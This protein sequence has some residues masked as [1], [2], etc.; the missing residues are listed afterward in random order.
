[1]MR[2]VRLAESSG[3]V[4]VDAMGFTLCREE[5]HN[6]TER[7]PDRSGCS[8]VGWLEKELHL[9]CPCCVLGSCMLSG[10]QGAGARALQ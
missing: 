9:S 1:M 3:E 4:R 7:K 2:L 5:L 8:L 6:Q 10:D